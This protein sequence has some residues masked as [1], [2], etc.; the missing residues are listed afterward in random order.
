MFAVVLFIVSCHFGLPPVHHKVYVEQIVNNAPEYDFQHILQAAFTEQLIKNEANGSTPLRVEV[1]SAD[2]RVISVEQGHQQWE[3]RLRVRTRLPG[4]PPIEFTQKARY[5]LAEDAEQ[6][7]P[8]ARQAA[9]REA[10]HALAADAVRVIV[11]AP[12]KK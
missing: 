1:I 2:E 10:A 8:I 11:F 12:E 3:L 5:V 9:Y 6:S 7:F 4:A